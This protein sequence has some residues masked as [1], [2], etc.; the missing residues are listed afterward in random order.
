MKW[1]APGFLL[2]G[3][4]WFAGVALAADNATDIQK[5]Q[6]AWTVVSALV[7]GEKS[8]R[9]PR[10]ILT[11]DGYKLTLRHEERSDESH[12]FKLTQ[13]RKPKQIDILGGD[14]VVSGIYAVDGNTLKLCFQKE[15]KGGR[16][17][18][19]SSTEANER[20]YVIFQRKK[21]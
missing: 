12:F 18:Q 9:W 19:F 20:T 8:E 1:S 10:T 5:L 21:R 11:I 16:P 15:N 7:D 17:E 3:L 13:N 2:A 14:E 4:A 6:G